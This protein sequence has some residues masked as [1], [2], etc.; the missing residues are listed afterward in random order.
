MLNNTLTGLPLKELQSICSEFKIPSYGTK[1]VV[2]ERIQK[3]LLYETFT[4]SK[5]NSEIKIKDYRLI[6]S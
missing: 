3:M 6:W 4:F 2:A 5:F 1:K